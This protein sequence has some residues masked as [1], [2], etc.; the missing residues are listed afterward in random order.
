MGRECEISLINR[1]KT[2]L[3]SRVIE[4]PT[5]QKVQGSY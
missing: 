5:S 1:S 4:M 3:Y 2:L